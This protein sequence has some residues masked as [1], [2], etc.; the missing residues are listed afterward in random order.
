MPSNTW[1]R[2]VYRA[3][4][5]LY[6]RLLARFFRPGREAAA[7][8]LALRAGERVLLVGVG[9]GED[10]PLLPAG[11]EAVGVDLSPSMLQ[12]ARRLA[13]TLPAAVELRQGD[14]A[15]LDLAPA[16]FDAVILNLVLS[17]VPDPVA[18]MAEV[19][20]VLRPGGRAVIFDKFAPDDRS[21]TL[22]RR[23]MSKVTSV[24]GTEIDRR[25]VDI[26]EGAP[27]RTVSD[28]PSILA[29]QYR[30]VLLHRTDAGRS[31]PH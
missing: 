22:P 4:A 29:G 21:P 20:R 17:V 9:T 26:L 16:S 30:V 10:L 31:S 7:R 14:A 28:E 18:A 24:L 2:I 1:N 12:R 13:S 27:C 8:A 19:M 5:P 25:L 6:D 23:I 11:V 3:W 15:N